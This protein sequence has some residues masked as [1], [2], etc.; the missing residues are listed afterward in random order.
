MAKPSV[1]QEECSHH[2]SNSVFITELT[3]NAVLS[4]PLHLG[5][6]SLPLGVSITPSIIC[7]NRSKQ[8][9]EL[10]H[11]CAMI[12]LSLSTRINLSCE[13]IS[14]HGKQGS[15]SFIEDP[16]FSDNPST[17]GTTFCLF[18][19]HLSVEDFLN[20]LLHCVYC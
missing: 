4:L 10:S 7:D 9:T 14:L 2:N 1:H 12:Q 16:L 5:C 8:S 15:P 13:F 17:Y 3:S 18:P 6:V 20:M 11:I 19:P